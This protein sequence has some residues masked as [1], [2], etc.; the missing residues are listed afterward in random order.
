MATR[1]DV[2]DPLERKLLYGQFFTTTNPFANEAFIRWIKKIPRL[3]SHKFLEP[4]AGANNIVVMI[5]DLG[6]DNDW[7][8]FDI[9]PVNEPEQNA[10][11]YIVNQRDS[12]NEYPIGFKVAITNPPYLA[13]NSATAKGL[14]YAGGSHADLY[15]KCLDV[16]LKNTEYV[17]AIIPESFIT[18]NAFHDRLATVISLTCR[19]FEDTEVPVCRKEPLGEGRSPRKCAASA[20]CL[21]ARRIFPDFYG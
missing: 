10:T 9:E 17:A 20:S 5:Q 14:E 15:L 2:H 1:P 8:C 18:Q 11:K 21:P 3:K 12:L 7:E 16:M 4:F 19:M 6:F 13:K